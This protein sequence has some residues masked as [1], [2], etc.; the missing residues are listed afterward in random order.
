M[1]GPP[2]D[3]RGI[4]TV[5]AREGGPALVVTLTASALARV[6]TVGMHGAVRLVEAVAIR[7]RPRGARMAGLAGC[8]A[9]PLV[10]ELILIRAQL[11]RR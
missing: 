7:G 6:C 2:L 11:E 1:I 4:P 3:A 5:A 10:G 9:A 8:T